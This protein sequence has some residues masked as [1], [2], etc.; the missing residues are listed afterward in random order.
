MENS[1]IDSYEKATPFFYW[2][3]KLFESKARD[4][5]LDLSGLKNGY[6]ILIIAPPT[7][8]YIHKLLESNSEGENHLIYFSDQ[9]KSRLEKRLLGNIAYIAGVGSI[10]DFPYESDK[11][12]VVFAYC[13]LDFLEAEERKIALSDENYVSFQFKGG[14]ADYER[15]LWRLAF[16][17]EI[18]EE[19]GFAV[20]IKEDTLFARLEGY[21]KDFIREK[22][23]I[24]G[25][26][27]IHSRQLDMIMSNSSM[28]SYYR[29]KIRNDIRDIVHSQ[30]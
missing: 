13:Y 17:K 9:M 29:L 26:L 5:S 3:S 22:L 21:E 1:F 24:L 19:Q 14:G 18:L 2:F 23:K 30:Q 25:Y 12:D 10:E 15:R 20:D 6:S 16:L 28:V 7:E 4:K 8:F 11:F 27:T